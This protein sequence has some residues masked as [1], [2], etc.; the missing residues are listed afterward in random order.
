MWV[1]SLGTVEIQY[2]YLKKP[3]QST[4]TALQYS[5]LLLL[6][7]S[8]ETNT[9]LTVEEITAKLAYNP[10]LITNEIL[11]F[12]FNPT[13]NP[14]KDIKN[15]L[16]STDASKESEVS[17]KTKVWLNKDFQASSNKLSTIPPVIKVSTTIIKY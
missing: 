12:I 17:L 10:K 2:L 15:G 11:G 4:S 8:D 7:Q 9:Q 3:H 5:I 14:K 6:E 16:I 13:F 1:Y